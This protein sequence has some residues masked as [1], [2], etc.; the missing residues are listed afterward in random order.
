M[1]QD[2]MDESSKAQGPVL[3]PAPAIQPQKSTTVGQS[4]TND[5][6]TE[7][8]V[9]EKKPVQKPKPKPRKKPKKVDDDADYVPYWF[10]SIF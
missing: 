4:A 7:P 3:Q 5:S 8:V 6:R 1:V 10:L 2:Y 9:E